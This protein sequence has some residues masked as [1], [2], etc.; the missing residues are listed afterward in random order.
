[1]LVVTGERDERV[2]LGY[3]EEHTARMARAGAWVTL[4]VFELAD[5]FLVFSYRDQLLTVL[6]P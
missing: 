5:H 3:V 4:K 1:M 6:E 2:P